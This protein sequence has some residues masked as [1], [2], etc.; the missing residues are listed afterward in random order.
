MVLRSRLT[1][2]DLTSLITK[3]EA[4]LKDGGAIDPDT[5][6]RRCF[7]YTKSPLEEV[8]DGVGYLY[9][10][11]GE[12]VPIEKISFVAYLLKRGISK[13]II[14]SLVF[15]PIVEIEKSGLVKEVYLYD[16]LMGD[17]YEEAYQK[18]SKIV[19][20]KEVKV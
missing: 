19:N 16:Y 7:H 11:K 2:R 14:S 9:D 13:E 8:L 3:M 6:P 10:E 5:P 15:S 18:I 4:A 1:N 20:F 12:N 17:S